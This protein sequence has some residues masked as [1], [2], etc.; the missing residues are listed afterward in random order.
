MELRSITV[1]QVE[2]AGY[3][4][5]CQ[6]AGADFFHHPPWLRFLSR[7][8]DEG[9]LYLSGIFEQDLLIGLLPLW[10]DQKLGFRAPNR[11][12]ATPYLGPVIALPEHPAKSAAKMEQLVELLTP[13]LKRYPLGRIFLPPEM[14][15]VRPFISRGFAV[16]PR[17]T[18]RIIFHPKK[19][20]SFLPQLRNKIR[21]AEK[22]GLT[23]APS[24]DV[25]TLVQLDKA[26]YTR[27]G[28]K[29][30]FSE[31]FL[32]QLMKQMTAEG[33]GRMWICHSPQGKALACRVVLQDELWGYDLLAASSDREGDEEEVGAGPYLVAQILEHLRRKVFGYDFCGANMPSIATFKASF[34]GNL[35]PF[36][37]INWGKFWARALSP[38]LAR[39]S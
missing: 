24:E 33:W 9:Y 34:G 3:Q 17:Y 29:P 31:N 35:E 38:G 6:Q 39:L 10:L 30:I 13:T 16:L 19:E 2:S 8:T 27:Q 37:C 21:R 36:F 25:E 12:P 18:N 15:D 14:N 5:I 26:T 4:S 28:K 22:A 20:L 23:V 32:R 1:E 11:A 7:L